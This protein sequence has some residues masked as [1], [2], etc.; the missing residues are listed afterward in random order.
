MT[1]AGSI[2][3]TPFNVQLIKRSISFAGLLAESLA[4]T[5][6]TVRMMMFLFKD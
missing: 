5:C 2:R 4:A 6:T 3:I 1:A